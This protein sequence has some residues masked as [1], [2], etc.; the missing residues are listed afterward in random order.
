MAGILP[1]E[2]SRR[3]QRML[4]HSP[5][6]AVLAMLKVVY[7]RWKST[8][9]SSLIIGSETSI[10]SFILRHIMHNWPNK[11]A[12]M[13]LGNVARAL[14]PKSKILIIDIVAI[15]NADST[16]RTSA[17]LFLLDSH[18][19]RLDYSIPLHFGSASELSKRFLGAHADDDERLR[20]VFGACQ[21]QFD[22]APPT[23]D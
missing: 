4:S 18:A 10:A 16:A 19:K 3:T 22:H 15:P 8:S 5:K 23:G 12:A 14:G 17:K 20:E 2:P 7:S 6:S 13:I 21:T 9:F 11:E 1:C